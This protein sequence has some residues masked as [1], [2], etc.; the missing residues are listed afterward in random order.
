MTEIELLLGAT[1]EVTAMCAGSVND[2]DPK[3]AS[4][5]RMGASALAV[6]ADPTDDPSKARRLAD[7]DKG[8]EPGTIPGTVALHVGH[9]WGAELASIADTLLGFAERVGDAATTASPDVT[10]AII[11]AAKG[12]P[13]S[14]VADLLRIVAVTLNQAA[15]ADGV[16]G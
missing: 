13:L 4:V 1:A 5:L 7:L 14:V 2:A 16:P 6:A 15:V 3:A 8:T 11:H 9:G 12:D 10:M